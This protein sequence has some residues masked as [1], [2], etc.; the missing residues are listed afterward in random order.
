MDGLISGGGGLKTGGL[1]LGG[2]LKVG[3]YGITVPPFSFLSLF[4]F[5]ISH[6]DTNVY[7][8]FIFH[9]SQNDFPLREYMCSA[10]QPSI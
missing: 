1:K 7:L 5:S 4:I 2:G 3:F 8:Y 6:L 10:G 9:N